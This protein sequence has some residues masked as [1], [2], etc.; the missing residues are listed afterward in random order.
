MTQVLSREYSLYLIGFVLLIS[1]LFAYISYLL[2]MSGNYIVL[3]I[4]II[5]SALLIALEKKAN[6]N[7]GSFI[8]SNS[9]LQKYGSF[10]CPIVISLIIVI[11]FSPT[12]NIYFLADDFAYIQLFHS[13]PFGYFTKLFFSELS[14]GIWGYALDELRPIYALSYKLQYYLSG[15]SPAGYHVTNIVTHAINSILVFSIVNTLT[16]G[17]KWIALVAGMLFAVAPVQSDTISWISAKTDSLGALFYLSAFYF[18]IQFRATSLR[19]YYFFSIVMC[20]LGLFT[21]ETLVTLPIMLVLYGLFF[22]RSNVNNLNSRITKPLLTYAPYFILTFIYLYLRWVAF[23]NLVREYKLGITELKEFLLRQSTYLNHL[24]LPFDALIENKPLDHRFNIIIVGVM[25]GMFITW[26]FYLI[27]DRAKYTQAIVCVLYFGLIWYLITIPPFFTVPYSAPRHLYLTS[28]GTY[29]AIAFL[30]FPFS[31]KVPTKITLA[32]LL[33][34]IFLI[35]IYGYTLVKDNSYWVK[36]GAISEKATLDIVR[37]SE[38][39]PYRSTVILSDLPYMT[40]N[41]YTWGWSLPFALQKPFTYDDFYSKYQVIEPPGLYCCPIEQWSKKT[42]QILTPLL[43]DKADDNINLYILE[44]DAENNSVIFRKN[45]F[46]KESFRAVIEDA[47]KK[48]IGDIE[49]INWDSAYNLIEN[50]TK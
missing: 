26:S 48:P 29:I 42:K 16:Q 44:W 12:I 5:F 39:I 38:N 28:A 8:G 3:P 23:G 24:L 50:L 22:Q 18:F 19:R 34:T 21:K 45:H 4:A 14:D 47:L 30:I 40:K 37:L 31:S 15:I 9:F 35:S 43:T 10:L 36:A 33:T 41:V 32:R 1:A 20:A 17:R 25:I 11:I 27:R 2:I 6:K 46:K 13:K 49:T 7:L